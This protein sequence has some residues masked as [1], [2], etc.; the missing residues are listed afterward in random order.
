V[1]L[2]HR[3][4]AAYIIGN[5]AAAAAAMEQLFISINI[6]PHI[7]HSPIDFL[8]SFSPNKPCCLIMEMRM[9]KLTGLELLTQ[10]QQRGSRVP[11][12]VVTAFGE[13]TSAVRA[14][15]LG[16]VEFME[17]P[18]NEEMLVECAQHWISV[19]STELAELKRR[20]GIEAKL[21]KLSP[22]EREVLQGLLDGKANKEIARELG[23]SP[24]AIEL[25]RSKLMSKMEASSLAELIRDTLCYSAVTTNKCR[26]LNEREEARFRLTVNT[27]ENMRD[28]CA[29]L[30]ES[31]QYICNKRCK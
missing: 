15:K 2:K 13:V 24:K 12:I 26:A 5:D 21:A 7:F 1:R 4:E 23:I 9:P 8:R 28:T 25:Y 22:R 6:E 29:E 19:H 3:D 30:I 20:A 18:V 14:M 10:L 17:K 16:A 11:A 27:P 31:S